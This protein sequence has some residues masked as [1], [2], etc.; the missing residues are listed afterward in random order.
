MMMWIYSYRDLPPGNM[1]IYHFRFTLRYVPGLVSLDI[2]YMLTTTLPSHH[3]S[4]HQ[5]LCP[6]IIYTHTHTYIYIYCTY[7][8]LRGLMSSD[9]YLPGLCPRTIFLITRTSVLG[10]CICIYTFTGAYVLG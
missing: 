7:L 9:R 4:N 5:D 2:L 10:P 1:H 8:Y 3:I 6:G